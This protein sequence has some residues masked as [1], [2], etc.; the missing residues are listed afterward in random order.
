MM[1]GP[2]AIS[3]D[4]PFHSLWASANGKSRMSPAD[5]VRRSPVA[6]S[7]VQPPLAIR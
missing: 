4:S 5:T 6:I 1:S 2:N 7:M 3:T